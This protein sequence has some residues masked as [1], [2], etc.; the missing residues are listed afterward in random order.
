MRSGTPKVA[1]GD[2][3]SRASCGCLAHQRLA[4]QRR[5]VVGTASLR[6]HR[7]PNNCAVPSADPYGLL[8][9]D[10]DPDSDPGSHPARR[11]QLLLRHQHRDADQLVSQRQQL[12]VAAAPRSADADPDPGPGPDAHTSADPAGAHPQS[13]PQRQAAPVTAIGTAGYHLGAHCHGRMH[14]LSCS[15]PCARR[16][17]SMLLLPCVQKRGPVMGPTGCMHLTCASQRVMSRVCGIPHDAFLRL[18]CRTGHILSQRG[19]SL[20]MTA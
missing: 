6:G 15:M 9:F 8:Y 10:P 2:L 1:T 13:H 16:A 3:A 19:A 14:D 5:L 20:F 12:R 17:G 18:L 4:S 11:Q 7:V